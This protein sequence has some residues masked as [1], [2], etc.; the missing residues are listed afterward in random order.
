MW[1]RVIPI[2]NDLSYMHI[3]LS[4]LQSLSLIGCDARVAIQIIN[5]S[6]HSIKVVDIRWC[7]D[8]EDLERNQKLI[9]CVTRELHQPP[10][11]KCAL[12]L[13]FYLF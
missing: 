1:S 12:I 8:L 5:A 2:T 6:I 9:P 4:C 11:K 10:Q 3:A 7:R 13:T